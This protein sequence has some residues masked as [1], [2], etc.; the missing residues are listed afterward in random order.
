MKN[1]HGN[2]IPSSFNSFQRDSST[3]NMNFNNQP[4]NITD[5]NRTKFIQQ[6][7][8]GV[9]MKVFGGNSFSDHL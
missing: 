8:G 7:N 6:Y 4:Q 5:H 3:K 9:G 2:N 1:S